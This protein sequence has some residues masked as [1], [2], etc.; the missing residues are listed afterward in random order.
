MKNEKKMKNNKSMTKPHARS[1]LPI[2]LI[3]LT[4]LL[5]SFVVLMTVHI[6]NDFESIAEELLLAFAVPT[7]VRSEHSY[8]VLGEACCQ[9]CKVVL[10]THFQNG[11]RRTLHVE[12]KDREDAEDEDGQEDITHGVEEGGGGGTGAHILK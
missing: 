12:S 8:S 10:S 3:V 11:W 6:I 2:Y 4:G 9:I 5:L 1:H 7:R